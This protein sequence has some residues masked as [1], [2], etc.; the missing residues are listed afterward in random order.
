MGQAPPSATGRSRASTTPD[1]ETAA[2]T[3]NRARRVAAIVTAAVLVADQATKLIAVQMLDGT[4]RSWGPVHLHV[5]HNSGGPFGL[6]TGATPLWVALTVIGGVIAGV[7]LLVVRRVDEF[8]VALAV[9]AGGVFGNLVDRIVASGP[10]RGAVIDWLRVTPYPRVFNLAD[11][12]LRVGA[13]A[14]VVA[15]IRARKH[16]GSTGRGSTR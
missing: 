1:D 11:V 10:D 7:G 5:I 3:A 4:R 12:A 8:T 14:L 13:V 2:G 16:D 15:A 9:M 6:A